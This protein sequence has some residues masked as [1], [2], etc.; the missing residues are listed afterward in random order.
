MKLGLD[1]YEPGLLMTGRLGGRASY[2][3][4]LT[5][6]EGINARDANDWKSASVQLSFD[7]GGSSR[8]A[9]YTALDETHFDRLD[10]YET[11]YE[12][13]AL[14]VRSNRG[15]SHAVTS[16]RVLIKH[17]LRP[18]RVYLDKMLR[19]GEHWALPTP[20]LEALRKIPPCDAAEPG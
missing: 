6:G 12:R 2:R 19:W 11:G 10:H 3:V 5:N 14:S 13:V 4:T 15:E 9:A 8:V 17:D 16:Y 18:S 20:Y 1:G 7:L